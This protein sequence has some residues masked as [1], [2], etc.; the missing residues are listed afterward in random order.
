[1]IREVLDPGRRS[2][3]EAQVTSRNLLV[4]LGGG[5]QHKRWLVDA[6]LT[7]GMRNVAVDPQPSEVK[8]NAFSVLMGV[9]L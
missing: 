1:V 2:D 6:R 4:I 9:R 7:R 5:L 3:I 8:T